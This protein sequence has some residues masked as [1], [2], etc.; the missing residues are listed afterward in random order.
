MTVKLPPI[1]VIS[2]ARAAA[3]RENITRRLNA[4]G[5]NYEIV[6]A[7]DGKALAPA[8]YA[9]RLRAEEYRIKFG[10]VF[11]PGGI[12]CIMSHHNLWRRIIGGKDD[13]AL[14][15][16]D[17]AAWDDDFAEVIRR[18]LLCEWHWEVVLFSDQKHRP[19]DSVLCDLGGGRQLVRIKS[20]AWSATAYLVSRS[21]AAK[22]YDYCQIIRA[23][24]DCMY[25]EY[26]KN[27]VAFYCAK[28]A[29]ARASGEVSTIGTMPPPKRTITE[30]IRGS[31]WRKTDRLRQTIYL[32]TNPPQKK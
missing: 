14:V 29:P 18:V 4:L 12:G 3:R 21:G 22:L 32:L 26:W 5:A 23:G 15:L 13:C 6:D 30:R 16:E 1:Y 7:V 19:I 25:A 20:R 24:A 28:P 31:I 9:H 10:C 8:Q 27:G 11:S 17:D 2:L